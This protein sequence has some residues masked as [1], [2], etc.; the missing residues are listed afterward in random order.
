[1]A[2]VFL[3]EVLLCCLP[4]RGQ[5]HGHGLVLG[6]VTEYTKLKNS[7]RLLML[8]PDGPFYHQD[9]LPRHPEKHTKN[10]LLS[11]LIE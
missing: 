9:R 2:S 1:M 8:C 3:G 11:R 6:M 5:G 7:T 10:I 4:P